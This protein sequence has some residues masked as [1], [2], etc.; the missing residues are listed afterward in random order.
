MGVAPAW[1]LSR[2]QRDILIAHLDGAAVPIVRTWTFPDKIRNQEAA[3]RFQSTEALI[4]RKFLKH[5][6]NKIT[7]SHTVMTDLGREAL[8]KTLADWADALM[9]ANYNHEDKM[10]AELDLRWRPRSAFGKMP[11]DVGGGQSHSQT[12]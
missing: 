10:A 1:W 6:D 11:D 12:K 3:T 8:A 5:A 7:P 4:G 9:R 2:T